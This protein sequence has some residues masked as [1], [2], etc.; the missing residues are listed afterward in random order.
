M[1][2]GGISSIAQMGAK[3]L[4]LLLIGP[5]ISRPEASQCWPQDEWTPP[6]PALENVSFKDNSLLHKDTGAEDGSILPKFSCQINHSSPPGVESLKGEK[7]QEF[8]ELSSPHVETSHQNTKTEHFVKRLK[9]LLKQT[10]Y[11][12]P[13][14]HNYYYYR[15]GDSQR[16]VAWCRDQTDCQARGTVAPRW[17]PILLRSNFCSASFSS[18]VNWGSFMLL[19]LISATI[20]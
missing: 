8:Q 14:G 1:N 10:C 15:L 7:G 3:M 18:C 5:A 11:K 4:S 13:R 6:V 16:P 17:S 9:I 12:P 2:F 20:K 19:D